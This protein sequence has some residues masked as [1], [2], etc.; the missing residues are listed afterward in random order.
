MDYYDLAF[1]KNASAAD[2]VNNDTPP[3]SGSANNPYTT[4]ADRAKFDSLSPADQAWLTKG[5]GKPDINDPFILARS[6]N[7]GK[8]ATAIGNG[9]S[10]EE[11]AKLD[12][13]QN[14]SSEPVID[15]A[16]TD[17]KEPAADDSSTK[18]SPTDLGGA[19]GGAS[20][21]ANADAFITALPNPLH[22]YPSYTYNLSLH[23]M[24]DADYIE[25]I[26]TE[27]Y[28]AK[29]VLIASAGRYNDSA[30]SNQFTRAPRFQEDFYFDH[31]SLETVCKPTEQ[32]RNTNTIKCDFT[33][34]EP[35]GFT[36]IERLL[37][38]SQDIGSKNYLDMAYLLQIDFFAMNEAGEV[39][40]LLSNLTK[41]VPLRLLKM[42]TTVTARG[43]EYRIE[44]AVFGH[45]A[46]SQVYGSAQ[47]NFQITGGTVGSFFKTEV[48][49]ESETYFIERAT[50]DKNFK[51]VSQN[52]SISGGRPADVTD[53]IRIA[54]FT[55]ALNNWQ[56][57]LLE[58][59]RLQHPDVYKFEFDP[60]IANAKFVL[61]KFV[62]H[63]DTAFVPRESAQRISDQYLSNGGQSKNMLD[64][65]TQTFA[66]NAGTAVDRIIDYIVR[67]STYI[68]NQLE[69]PEDS[70][71]S[72]S[73]KLK[74]KNEPLMW[75]KIVPRVKFREFDSIRNVYS[76]EITY[77]VKK[78]E[79][80][81]L[82]L[83]FAPR[84]VE[85]AP[86][87]KYDYIYTGRNVDI[88]DFELKFNMTYYT[89]TSAFKNSLEKVNPVPDPTAGVTKKNFENYEGCD[90][91]YGLGD[92]QVILDGNSV[93]PLQNYPRVSADTKGRATGSVVYSKQ[94]AAADL[95]SYILTK[96]AGDMIHIKLKIIGDPH[97]IKQDDIFYRPRFSSDLSQAVESTGDPR[98]TPN[99][100]IRT[101]NGYVYVNLTFR[102]PL[103]INEP[104]GLMKFSDEN[105]SRS[106][107][108]GLYMLVKAI[109]HFQ[110]GQ[111]TQELELVRAPRQ[112]EDTVNAKI[113][114][115]QRSE[116]TVTS[117]LS[118]TDVNSTGPANAKRPDDIDL[119]RP[120]QNAPDS[121][122]PGPD[123]PPAADQ[124][125]LAEVNATAA[126]KPITQQTEP[127]A[128][129]PDPNAQRIAAL[130]TE[131]QTSGSR[132]ESLQSQ[133]KQAQNEA[134]NQQY[135]YE[136][137]NARAQQSEAAGQTELAAVQRRNANQALAA[138][139]AAQTNAADLQT[140]AAAAQAKYDATLNEYT[141][142]VKPS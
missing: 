106:A 11:Q 84:G 131:L 98:L 1:P 25:M 82:P 139:R 59:R 103:D 8:P 73:F 99:G 37:K 21:S 65:N 50:T 9:L 10:P 28:V 64:Q 124:K 127:V 70:A 101:D 14:S 6:P 105:L 94:T 120:N 72:K 96:S 36:L 116:S 93:A 63:Q 47:L 4:P 75:W 51:N 125:D 42:D 60:D 23:L 56:Q 121:Q 13:A 39:T 22:A 126:E 85:T 100:S 89:A 142:L 55:T 43:T 123:I 29:R 52:G 87:K 140:Q 67:N 81:N 91:S 76:K 48:N 44:A 19:S 41:R 24:T 68:L 88:L 137:A 77:Y 113:T 117:A 133:A 80:K 57:T 92:G 16:T 46:F 141:G 122:P 112:A 86:L 118:V 135:L 5:G 108:S 115:D 107:F 3:S 7:K 114:S 18:K 61:N 78:Y 66:V 35:Y 79:I 69:L 12:Q 30:G 134:D 119:P 104:D 32:N 20:A 53:V 130:Q 110:N 97:Y 109:N 95:E 17:K 45:Q 71:D 128:T 129:P 31:L 49:T 26:E 38:T 62:N 34:I 83:D 90:A 58:N 27:Q 111:F 54:S 132:A 33:L 136:T 15:P 138:A 2:A 102:T 74:R 40:G